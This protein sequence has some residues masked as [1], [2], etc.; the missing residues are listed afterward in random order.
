MERLYGQISH[1]KPRPPSPIRALPAV[2]LEDLYRLFNPASPDNPFRTPALRWRN[3]LIFLLLL[4]LGLRRSEAALLPADAVKDDFDSTTGEVRCWLNV[5]ETSYEEDEDSRYD[6]P[7][8]KTA[9]SRRQIPVSAEV[10]KVYDTVVQELW[11]FFGW[12]EASVMPRHYAR[13]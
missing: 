8:L 6:A 4:H 5:D 2:V 13:A 9:H 10:V 11:V 7:G 3:F 12:T 1:S